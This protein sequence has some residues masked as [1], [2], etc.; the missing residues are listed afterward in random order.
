VSDLQAREQHYRALLDALPDLLFRVDRAGTYLEAWPEDRPDLIVRGSQLVGRNVRDVLPA[1][2]VERL[3]RVVDDVCETG[4]LGVIEYDL[5]VH[6]Q[7]Q[8]FEARV[9]RC[10]VDEVLAMIRN[11]TDRKRSEAEVRALQQALQERLVELQASRARIV[12]TA[13]AE[14]RRLERDIHDGAQQRLLATRLSLRLAT[15]RLRRGDA[16]GAQAV[17]ADADRQLE[18]AVDE[19]RAL[20]HGIHPAVLT[21]EGLGAALE[22]LARRSPVPVEL[23]VALQDRLPPAVETAVYFFACEALTN[24]VKHADASKSVVTIRQDGDELAVTVDDDGVGGAD[25][26]HGRGLRGL[27]DRVEALGG[28]MVVENLAGGGTRLRAGIPCG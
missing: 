6:G 14:R 11:V 28:E 19:L 15:E 5:E 12:E 22:V 9:V 26:G 21:D 20:A 7:A 24:V 13:D 2:L 1:D 17:I 25:E 18:A 3:R 8:T 4:E 16:D 27:R 23:T 10:A